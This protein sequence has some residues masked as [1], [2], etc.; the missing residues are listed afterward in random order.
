MLN[1]GAALKAGL[2]GA[3]VL[4]V[5]S[6]IGLIP[7]V[8]IINCILIPIAYIGIGVL[9]AYWLSPPRSPAAGAVTGGVAGIIGG[10]VGGVLQGIVSGIQYAVTGGARVFSQLPPE[11]IRQLRDAGVDPRL[12]QQVTQ[13]GFFVLTL[14]ICCFV[15]TVISALLAAGGGAV[16]ASVSKE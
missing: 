9:A 10:L 6:L 8:G 16:Y 5:L 7:C 2:I 12:I 3:G 1:M 4:L 13:P 14:A 15:G 11:V